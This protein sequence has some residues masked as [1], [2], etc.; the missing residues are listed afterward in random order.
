MSVLFRQLVHRD[1]AARNVLVAEGRKMKISDFGLSRD[2][3]EE[4]SYVKRS[5]VKKKKRTGNYSLW[6]IL[7]TLSSLKLTTGSL[8]VFK[9]RIPVKWMAIESL[10]DHIYTTQSDV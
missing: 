5:K 10:F 6:C 8:T 4:D 9:G 7:Y 2:V 1:L 3:Y